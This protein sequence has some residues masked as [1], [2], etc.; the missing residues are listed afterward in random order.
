MIRNALIREAFQ[1]ESSTLR[2]VESLVNLDLT[3]E[4]L[5]IFGSVANELIETLLKS[6]EGHEGPPPPLP[7]VNSRLSIATSL[8]QLE[9][10][11]PTNLTLNS[12][13]PA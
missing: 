3:E 6:I 10:V 8:L 4:E 5:K 12:D 9:P 13:S 2:E 1:V 7:V 11:V